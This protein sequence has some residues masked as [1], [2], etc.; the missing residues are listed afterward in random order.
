MFHKRR[1]ED[2]GQVLNWLTSKA[3]CPLRNPLRHRLQMIGLRQPRNQL[4]R[5][6]IVVAVFQPHKPDAAGELVA[7]SSRLLKGSRVPWQI[8]VEARSPSR[9]A[10]RS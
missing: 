10:V 4:A 1:G 8:G 6:Q 9:C 7:R 2:L 3:V 5:L